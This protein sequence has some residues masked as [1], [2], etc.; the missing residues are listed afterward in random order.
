MAYLSAAEVTA[1][2]TTS[3][4]TS[5]VENIIDEE[6][7]WLAR[8]IGPLTGAR[9]ETFQDLEPDAVLRLRR[10]TNAVTVTDDGDALTDVELRWRGTRVARTVGSWVGDV[11]VTY[12]PNDEQEVRRVLF[13][14][15]RLALT[16][17]GSATGAFQS[18]SIGDYSYTL[19]EGGGVRASRERLV[20]SLLPPREPFSLR[21][22]SSVAA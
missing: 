7:A 9:T 14:L 17:D 18:E 4:P 19:A 11:A 6:E 16:D 13:D 2:I 5:V 8:R 3:R 21:L 1:R 15:I 20:R 12:T 10:P 22:R